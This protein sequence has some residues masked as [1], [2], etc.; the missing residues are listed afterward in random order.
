MTSMDA[1]DKIRVQLTDLTLWQLVS[2]IISIAL[3]IQSRLNNGPWGQRQS[4]MPSEPASVHEPSRAAEAPSSSSAGINKGSGKGKGARS[5]TSDYEDAQ[6]ICDGECIICG[7]T[8]IRLQ[9]YHKHCKCRRHLHY[10]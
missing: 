4:D 6:Y 7:A 5:Q 3:E 1:M 8:C 2:L 10:R 9:P